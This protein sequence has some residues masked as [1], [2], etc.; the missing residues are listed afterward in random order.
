MTPIIAGRFEQQAQVQETMADLAR[1]GFGQDAISSFYLNPP[2][3]HHQLPLGGDHAQSPG[4]EESPQGSVAGAA[5][6][7]AVGA[8]VGA[9]TTPVSGPLGAVTGGLVGA[10]V[11]SLAGSLGKMKKD[12]DGVKGGYGEQHSEPVIRTSGMLVAV[13]I[14]TEDEADRAIEILRAHGAVDIERA[15]GNIVN[16]D[17]QDFDP[18]SIPL[19]VESSGQA[20]AP[21]TQASGIPP[22]SH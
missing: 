11:G 16:G 3:R 10:Y 2:G 22:A 14:S 1:S 5:T 17:W 21:H 8:A 7:G 15:Q 20:N 19:L 6:G 9:A 12:D 4:A 18:D 13:A